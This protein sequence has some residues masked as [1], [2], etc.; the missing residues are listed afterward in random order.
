MPMII[1]TT[2]VLPFIVEFSGSADEVSPLKELVIKLE[3]CDI[4]VSGQFTDIPT[5]PP[6]KVYKAERRLPVTHRIKPVAV[7]PIMYE[8]EVLDCGFRT[9]RPAILE[10]HMTNHPIDCVLRPALDR[11]EEP[12]MDIPVKVVASAVK[13]KAVKR[14]AVKRKATKS[15]A[16]SKSRAVVPKVLSHTKS[17]AGII[18]HRD[19]S[20]HSE[21]ETHELS[22]Q[23]A[24]DD[25]TNLELIESPPSTDERSGE[26]QTSKTEAPLDCDTTHLASGLNPEQTA[27]LKE[28]YATDRYPDSNLDRRSKDDK[29]NESE[30]LMDD[31]SE[32]WSDSEDEPERPD[33][34]DSD[35][36]WCP[37]R[38]DPEFLRT[39][40]YFECKEA[41]C[42]YKTIKK[43]NMKQHWNVVHNPNFKA[44]LCNICGR[45]VRHLN[46]HMYNQHTKRDESKL[47]KCK[48]CDYKT[49]THLRMQR[50][51]MIHSGDK[52]YKCT[53]CNYSSN[54]KTNLNTHMRTHTGDKPYKCPSCDY[55]AAHNVTLKGHIKAQHPE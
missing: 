42:E 21:L 26:K 40:L 44:Q 37:L 16:K 54:Q 2:A 38:H 50:H 8:C 45:E 23:P 39:G 6:S 52:P 22:A 11:L 41:G 18:S 47:L 17:S 28:L 43:D 19:T 25:T 4:L 27:A 5:S 10:H 9:P 14:K 30:S 48:F 29:F 32:S 12:E 15:K 46:S 3:P 33:D 34:S 7:A 36:D 51:E 35:P 13:C 1:L 49:Y 24:P 53:Q 55:T 31:D 20:Y